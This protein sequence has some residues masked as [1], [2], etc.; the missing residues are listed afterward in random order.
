MVADASILTH[1]SSLRDPRDNRGK[2]HVLLDIVVIA[3]CAVISGAEGWEDITDYGVAKQ[4]SLATFLSLPHGIP[5][6]DTFARVFARLESSEFQRCF[7]SWVK[8]ISG[9]L[10]SEV[11]G[12]DGKVLCHSGDEDGGK[13][14]Y[15][16]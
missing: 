15:I 2:K 13:R 1:F 7:L 6:A 12:I 9:R 16:W 14:R 3:L 11:I 5:S 8:T 4:G 10:A